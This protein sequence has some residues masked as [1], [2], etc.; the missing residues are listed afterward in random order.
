[1]D[2]F[3]FVIR[4]NYRIFKS[5]I[6]KSSLRR[7]LKEGGYS[8]TT[9]RVR[10]KVRSGEAYSFSGKSTRMWYVIQVISGKE[11]ATLNMIK[12]YG[13]QKYIKECFSP[14]YERRRKY[15]GQWHQEKAILF[16]G[17][18]FVISNQVEELYQ[19]L[20]KIPE[21]TKLLGVGEKW[22]AMTKEDVEIVELLSG[23]ERVVKFSEGYIAGEKVVV[24]KGPLKG[25]EGTIRKVDRHK[26][27]AYLEIPMFGRVLN[28]QVGLE[29]V[30][31]S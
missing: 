23:K 10:T 24:V 12:K 19:A 2:L 5:R 15:L 13:A 22:T 28:A 11:E 3:V 25:M 4:V 20:K 9:K 8:S 21:L 29:I 6:S 1:M 30:E 26:R 31:K 16:P 27:K 14:R 7:V 17:Y 18:I